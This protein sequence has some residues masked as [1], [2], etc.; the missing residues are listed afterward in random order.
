MLFENAI[1]SKK[2][3]DIGMCYA[4]AYYSKL[5]WTVSIPITDSQDYDLVVDNGTRLFKVQVKTTRFKAPSGN[6]T[7][8][9]TTNGGNRSGSGKT[10]KFNDNSS[11]LL[12]VLT[13]AGECYSIPTSEINSTTIITLCEK[14]LPYRVT[15]H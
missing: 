10:K 14:Y 6:Y 12:F 1:N 3:G 5:G 13:E 2:Q 4:M 9:L 7:A 8:S 11:D 15:L